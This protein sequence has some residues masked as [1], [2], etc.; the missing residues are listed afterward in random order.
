MIDEKLNRVMAS[1]IAP[2]RT[3]LLK[4]QDNLCK[5]CGYEIDTKSSDG[6]VLDHDHK[7]G[8]VRAVLHRFCNSM[9]GKVENHLVRTKMPLDHLFS[10]APGIHEYMTTDYSENPYHPKYRTEDEKKARR[11]KKAKDRRKKKKEGV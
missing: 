8:L 3:F 7:T 4:K 2:Y 6:P 9:L 1:K 10:F 5:L 11:S